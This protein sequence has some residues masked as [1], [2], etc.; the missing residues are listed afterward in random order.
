MSIETPTPKV[1]A[2]I[3]NAVGRPFHVV[4]V[5]PGDRY[6]LD[7]KLIHDGTEPFVEFWDATYENDPRFTP[8]R[9]QFVTRYYLSTLT[10][11]E[12]TMGQPQPP[13]IAGLNLCGYMPAWRVSGRNV[14]EALTAVERALQGGDPSSANRE[15][16][17][18]Q[19][20]GC[21]MAWLDETLAGRDARD[22]AM[23]AMSTLS[24]AQ[25]L[26]QHDPN[27]NNWF[28]RDCHANTIRQLMN[29][30]KYTID[31]AVPR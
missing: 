27:T 26:I 30:A 20:F 31:K 2:R 14:V 12:G 6:G 18:R 13:R 19:M 15:D 10:C 8:G 22:L 16:R 7:D 23:Y 24:N 29:L 5:L 3:I 21:T 28:I 17:E 9:G 11:E 25:Q 4:L 1:V